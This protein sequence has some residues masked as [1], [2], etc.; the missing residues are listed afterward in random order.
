MVDPVTLLSTSQ[1]AHYAFIRQF[2]HT[3]YNTFLYTYSRNNQ[4]QRASH[5]NMIEFPND[6]QRSVLR[7]SLIYFFLAEIN[8]T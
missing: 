6:F 1:V 4:S 3:L 5:L 8:A 7:M 2:S